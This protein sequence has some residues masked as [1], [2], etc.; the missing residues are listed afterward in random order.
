MGRNRM[1]KIIRCVGMVVIGVSCLVRAEGSPRSAVHFIAV[2]DRY[3]LSVPW[4]LAKPAIKVPVKWSSRKTSLAI[5]QGHVKDAGAAG[6][7]VSGGDMT[8]QWGRTKK[9]FHDIWQERLV[10]V[11]TVQMPHT[12]L[13]EVYFVSMEGTDFQSWHF[14][15]FNPRTST[16]ITLTYSWGHD[17]KAAAKKTS[18]NFNDPELADEREMLEGLTYDPDYGVPFNKQ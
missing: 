8:S 14:N 3:S 5:F 18:A 16:L 11:G 6:K 4:D 9:V 15:L 1:Y 12:G 2:H 7:D 17:D 10:E 13:E